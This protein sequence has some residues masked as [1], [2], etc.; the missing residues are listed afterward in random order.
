[1]VK[2]NN[3]CTWDGVVERGAPPLWATPPLVTFSLFSGGCG[4]GGAIA[5]LVGN[6]VAKVGNLV[7]KVGNLVATARPELRLAGPYKRVG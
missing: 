2:G 7:A 3:Y 1:M 5:R 6:L 4:E